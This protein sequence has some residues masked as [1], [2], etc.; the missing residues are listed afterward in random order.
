MKVPPLV[1]DG[2]LSAVSPNPLC[3][4]VSGPGVM[5]LCSPLPTTPSLVL[6]TVSLALP[7]S[8]FRWGGGEWEEGLLQGR[9]GPQA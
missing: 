2:M 1:G 5:P 7:S 4:G 8:P 9:G 3:A 6:P